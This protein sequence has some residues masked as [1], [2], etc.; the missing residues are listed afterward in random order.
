MQQ[1]EKIE[2][3]TDHIKTYIDTNYQLVKL[4]ATERSAA[5][6]SVMISGVLLGAMS[7]L[8]LLFTSVWAG[9]YLS[10]LFDDSYSG[11]AIVAGVYMILAIV[12][13]C[14][15]KQLLEKRSRNMIIDKILNK[16]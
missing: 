1:R 6:G 7:V 8:I 4:Q 13:L 16:K 5:V 9:F 15:G 12:F 3:L 10:H 14:G 11:F 2:D